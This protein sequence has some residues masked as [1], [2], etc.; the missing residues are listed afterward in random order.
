MMKRRFLALVLAATM[1]AGA[2]NV[3]AFTYSA[4]DDS[5]AGQTF[6]MQ[7]ASERTISFNKDWK[8]FLGNPSNEYSKDCLLYTSRCV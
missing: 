5:K 3:G 7:A 4:T 2:S 1:I 8:F 6:D